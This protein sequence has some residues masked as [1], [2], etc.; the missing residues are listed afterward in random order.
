MAA[1]ISPLQCGDGAL[2]QTWEPAVSDTVACRKT[3][4]QCSFLLCPMFKRATGTCYNRLAK[5][6]RPL[7]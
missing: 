6:C 5:C 2:D 4:G 1:E 3:K 7:W